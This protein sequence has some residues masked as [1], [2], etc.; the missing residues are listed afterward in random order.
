VG[1]IVSRTFDPTQTSALMVADRDGADG[2]SFEAATD[3]VQAL[4][5]AGSSVARV[6]RR[7]QD[8]ATVR[9]QIVAGVNSGPLVVNWMGHGSIDVWT[10]D[11]LLRGSDAAVAH[12]REPPAALRDDDVSERLL[13][14]DGSR[15]SRRVGLEGAGRRRLRRLGLFGDDRAERAG[16]G[17]P[18]AVPHHLRGGRRGA[19]RRRGQAAKAATADRDV[20]RTWVFFGDPSSSCVEGRAMGA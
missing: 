3:G 17:Q 14:G 8:A 5:P 18:R 10:G 2:Y 6:N 20:R 12:E 4:L 19:P 9:S 11:G 7:A 13:R 1:K 15:Q 16:G